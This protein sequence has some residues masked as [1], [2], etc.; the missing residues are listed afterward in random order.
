MLNLDSPF[1]A[2]KF[3]IVYNEVIMEAYADLKPLDP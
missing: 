2:I 3:D 1:L